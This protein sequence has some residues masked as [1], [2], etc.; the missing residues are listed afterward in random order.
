MPL[1]SQQSAFPACFSPTSSRNG[2]SQWKPTVF[3]LHRIPALPPTHVG[4]LE[5]VTPPS[6]P[7]HL[8]DEDRKALISVSHAHVSILTQITQR[9]SYCVNLVQPLWRKTW[10]YFIKLNINTSHHPENP[11]LGTDPR[12]MKACVHQKPCARMFI[13]D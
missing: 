3:V 10:Q 13:M 2:M 5:Q 6:A 12:E 11:L 1:Q 8:E 7:P 9:Q 4:D